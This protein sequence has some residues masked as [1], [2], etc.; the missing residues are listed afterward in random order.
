MARAKRAGRVRAGWAGLGLVLLCGPRWALAGQSRD[1]PPLVR[2]TAP[3]SGME[4]HS[5]EEFRAN[6]GRLRGVVEACAANSAACVRQ[7]VGSDERVGDLNQ[8]GG[9]EVHWGW[10]RDALDKARTAKPEDRAKTLAE[11]Q[12]RLARM[13]E[14]AARPSQEA[15]SSEAAAF[16]R[17]RATT[18]AVLRQPEFEAAPGPTWWER[19]EA[20]LLRLLGRLFDGLGRVGSAAPWLGRLLEWLFF[21]GAAVGLMVFLLR[22]AARQRLRVTLGEGLAATTAWD[23]E[24]NDW[25][26][27]AESHAAAGEWRDAVHCLYWAAIVLLEGRRAWRHNPTRTP[28]EYVRLVR[29]GSTQQTALRGLTQIF[30]RVWYGLREADEAEFQRAQGCFA[31]I[32]AGDVSTGPVRVDVAGTISPEGA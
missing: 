2:A 19:Q 24:A 17:A 16:R 6:V 5:V 25:Q 1:G 15:A 10:L 4:R 32:A 23:R 8:P 12:A 13:T 28:R 22:T 29:A 7:S 9:Y 30:E 14:E 20:K 3:V 27:Q 11:T 18:D 26:R 31:T 21:V